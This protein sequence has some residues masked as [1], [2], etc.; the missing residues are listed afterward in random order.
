VIAAV[1]V[2]LVAT[3]WASPLISR[4]LGRIG[5]SIVVRV[6]GLILCALAVQFVLIGVGDDAVR[7]ERAWD[8]RRRQGAVRRASAA[9]ASWP[10]GRMCAA[11]TRRS[12]CSTPPAIWS[13]VWSGERYT[14]VAPALAL[15]AA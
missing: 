13:A 11:S 1:S 12:T 9:R 15:V 3:F 5:M 4:V 2:V 10:F 7:G 14:P 8:P 6:L